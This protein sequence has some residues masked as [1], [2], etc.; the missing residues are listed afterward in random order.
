MP[1]PKRET[2]WLRAELKGEGRFITV[3][4]SYRD[5]IA[6]PTP[7]RGPRI[8]RCLAPRTA[9]FSSGYDVFRLTIWQQIDIRGEG[10]TNWQ[11]D[12]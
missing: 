12:P 4:R 10:V 7:K 11:H 5:L 3:R 8:A 2:R 6:I 9:Y 1:R